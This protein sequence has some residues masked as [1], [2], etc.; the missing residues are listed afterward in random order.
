MYWTMVGLNV[1]TEMMYTLIVFT[2]TLTCL[3]SHSG[4][5]LSRC[6][7]QIHGMSRVYFVTHP[8]EMSVS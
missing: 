5:I 1:A 7:D 8:S 2:V 3:F 4:L 6:F